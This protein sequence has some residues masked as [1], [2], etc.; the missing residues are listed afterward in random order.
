M[1]SGSV[2]IL[3]LFHRFVSSPDAAPG[4]TLP[5]YLR[6]PPYPLAEVCIPLKKKKKRNCKVA[7]VYAFA[8]IF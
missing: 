3:V 2:T 1:M 7:V 4:Y 5:H 8:L 6:V